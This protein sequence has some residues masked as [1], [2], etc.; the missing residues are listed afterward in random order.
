MVTQVVRCEQEGHV[1]Y[2]APKKPVGLKSSNINFSVSDPDPDGSW[3]FRR[4]VSGI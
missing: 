1:A 3:S 4:S 2:F